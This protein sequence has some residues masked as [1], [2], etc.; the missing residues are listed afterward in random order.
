MTTS[1]LFNAATTTD[2][3]RETFSGYTLEIMGY[4]F[5]S[6]EAKELIQKYEAGDQDVTIPSGEDAVNF[7]AVSKETKTALLVAQAAER[8]ARSTELGEKFAAN[9]QTFIGSKNNPD[10]EKNGG[11]AITHKDFQW[12]GSERDPEELKVAQATM[13]AAQAYINNEL[14]SIYHSIN[15]PNAP[16]NSETLGHVAADGFRKKAAELYELSADM[17]KK[18]GHDE[19]AEKTRAAAR[20]IKRAIKHDNAPTP[21]QTATEALTRHVLAVNEANNVAGEEVLSVNVPFAAALSKVVKLTTDKPAVSAP[22]YR[23]EF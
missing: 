20:D 11:K 21:N 13:M 5:P 4:F 9:Q 23:P 10:F 8:T 12:V 17:L 14:I 15:T 2:E 22:N 16:D 1:K 7:G 6:D 19:I 18:E 3:I